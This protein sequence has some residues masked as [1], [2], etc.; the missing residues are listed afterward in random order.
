MSLRLV[1]GRSGTGKTEF[2]LNEIKEKINEEQKIYIVVPEQFSF[3]M[4]KRLLDIIGSN[5]VMNAEVLTLSRMATRVIENTRGENK[6]RLTKCGMAMIIYSCIQHLKSE[7]HFLNDTD[8]NLELAVNSINEFKKH[9]ITSDM[10]ESVINGAEDEYLKIK[11]LDIKKILDEYTKRISMSFIDETDLLEI[12]IDR[13]EESHMFDDT[14]I[15]VDEFM[16]FTLEEYKVLEKLLKVARMVTLTISTDDLENLN[17]TDIFYFNNITAKRITDIA[18]N[19]DIKIDKNVYLEKNKRTNKQDLI[20]L[21][22]NLYGKALKVYDKEC[23][24]LEIFMAKN[25]YTE[26]Q[27]V[28]EKI[29]N[30]V[31]NENARFR[32]IGIITKEIDSYSFDAEVI[33]NQYNIPLFID[34]KKD[35]NNNILMIYFTS[36]FNI[37]NKNWSYESVFSFIKSGLLDIE[38][39]DIYEIENYVIKWG[40][41]GL[42]KYKNP[43]EYEAKNDLQ[44]RVNKTREKIVNHILSFKDAVSNSKKAKDKCEALVDFINK[45]E[46]SKKIYEEADKLEKIGLYEKSIEYRN[47]LKIF[48]DVLDEI[49]LVFENE[50][51]GIEKFSTLLELGISKSEFGTLPTT[52]DQVVLGDIDRTRL[53][54]IK[55]LFVVRNE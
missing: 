24:S 15:Y 38:D 11:L 17:D 26:L 5:S 4:E 46:I 7:L 47:S 35:V 13:V 54:E 45:N 36:L 51:M 27:Y 22:E 3:S 52:V 25:P 9:G 55:Y 53:N 10:I 2:L 49:V 30:L 31:K 40:I 19:N 48:Y 12:L 41:K 6:T 29:L 8:K 42:K 34:E 37:L 16:G 1:Y 43:F 50:E 18:K 28:A 21:E 23:S 14:L 39:K 33:F 44:E 32:D 20:F